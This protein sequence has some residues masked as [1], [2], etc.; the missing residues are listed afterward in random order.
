[1]Q[2]LI[3]IDV[4]T[5]GTKS[6][7]YTADGKLIDLSYRNYDL[8]YPREGWVE[9]NA[10]H[11]WKAVRQTIGE[12][13]NRNDVR[14]KVAALSLSTQGGATVLL[15]EKYHPIHNAIGWLDTRAKE[16]QHLLEKKIDR[17]E[18]KKICGWHFLFALN[19]PVIFWIKEKRPELFKRTRYFSSTIEYINY[20]LTGRFVIDYSNLALTEFLDL[21]RMDWSDRLLEI[22]EIGRE[23]VACIIPSGEKIGTLNRKASDELGLPE[24]VQVIS[25]AHDQYC[26][27]IGSGAIRVG[28]CMLSSGTA[29]VLLVT[30]ERSIVDDKMIINPGIH[31]LKD[32]YGLMSS[33][34]SAGD[35]LNWFHST[36][37]R[38]Y[39][40]EQLGREVEKVPPGSDGMLFIPRF[41]SKSRNA[42]FLHVDHSHTRYHFARSIFEGVALANRRHLD[43]YG[44]IGIRIKQLIM[45][46][47]GAS[48]SVWP[49]IVADVSYIPIL[50][51]DQK[52]A[53]CAGAAI[54]A[55]VGCGVYPSI[56]GASMKFIRKKKRIE[57]NEE[58]KAIYEK[59]YQ[60]FV[61]YL[62]YV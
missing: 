5:N 51:P 24:N 23:N 15:D 35:S 47:G 33:V 31:L 12:L 56:E 61:P 14:E 27:D 1:M 55:G 58:N 6:V 4:G 42:S 2:Y 17:S 41:F 36:F 52:E 8:Q 48:S 46:G 32:K 11:W 43:A 16:S 13:V 19:F 57:P 39:S 50:I 26:A 53:A 29:W 22:A 59:S 3:G 20:K 62:D 9:Q 21:E 60:Q 37:E 54:L 34:P 45:I 10:F 18:L 49:Q 38:H 25:G 40:L 28:D 7:L 44:S 30:S